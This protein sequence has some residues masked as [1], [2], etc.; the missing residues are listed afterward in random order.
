MHY[1]PS[2]HCRIIKTHTVT[3]TILPVINRYW[4][5][6]WSG[7]FQYLH[8]ITSDTRI[9]YIYTHAL[10]LVLLIIQISK[11]RYTPLDRLTEVEDLLSIRLLI[12]RGECVTEFKAVLLTRGHERTPCLYPSYYR[13]TWW[14]GSFPAF[15][16]KG[17]PLNTPIINMGGVLI[18]I[19][20]PNSNLGKPQW[21]H[22]ATGQL[23]SMFILS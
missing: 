7:W 16:N 3:S 10:R 20:A 13:Q 8:K 11:I 19:Y 5:I 1:A 15:Q 6:Q 2:T 23:V 12:G 9:I 14:W 4:V 18:T 21:I 22:C 17:R